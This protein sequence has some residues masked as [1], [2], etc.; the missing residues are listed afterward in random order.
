MWNIE[1]YVI[2]Q[3]GKPITHNKCD[4]VLM[5]SSVFVAESA[6]DPP[7]A[8][9]YRAARSFSHPDPLHGTPRQAW[10]ARRWTGTYRRPGTG[11]TALNPHP[12]GLALSDKRAM[13]A[14][15]SKTMMCII[16]CVLYDIK[17]NGCRAL[18]KG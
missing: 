15:L 18:F 7:V 13:I 8:G 3:K 1:L 12:R 9:R 2:T 4:K 14:G 17:K 16:R 10:D 5:E 6:W 11:C